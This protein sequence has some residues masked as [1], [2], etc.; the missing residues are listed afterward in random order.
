MRRPGLPGAGPARSVR[1]SLASQ[2]LGSQA[3]PPPKRISDTRS[4]LLLLGAVPAAVGEGC[5][6]DVH[7]VDFA[8]PAL[9][10]LEPFPWRWQR[11]DKGRRDV[12]PLAEDAEV[13][14]L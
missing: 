2:S 9:A 12:S 7:A 1:R 14:R 10:V 13:L 5:D 6:D 11:H 3:H 8:R 4:V